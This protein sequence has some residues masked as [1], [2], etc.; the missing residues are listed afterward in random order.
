MLARPLRLPSLAT[1]ADC[2]VSHARSLSPNEGLYTTNM[3]GDGPL[4]PLPFY[5]GPGTTLRLQDKS[6]G[7]DGLYETKVVWVSRG[8]YNGPAMIRV[9]RLDAAGRGHVRLLYD[10]AASRDD[11]VI[12][13]VPEDPTNWP[14]TTSIPA[15]GC[16]AYQVDGLTFTEIIVF[17][18]VA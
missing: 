7:P 4:Y 1:G 16:Y 8:G 11:S 10:P 15:P 2:P 13:T 18:V 9:G 3:F 12:F 5:F 17:R 6:P 14:S